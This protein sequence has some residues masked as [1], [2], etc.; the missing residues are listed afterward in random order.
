MAVLTLPR[1]TDPPLSSRSG[2]THPRAWSPSPF[3]ASAAAL[4]RLRGRESGRKVR[5]HDTQA[6]QAPHGYLASRTAQPS[7]GAHRVASQTEGWY[8]IVRRPSIASAR[9]RPTA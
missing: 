2:T 3:L 4:R 8:E 1:A 9:L 7:I 5:D 6:H